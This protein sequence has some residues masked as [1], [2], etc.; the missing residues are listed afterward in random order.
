MHYQ[1][2]TTYERLGLGPL[3]TTYVGISFCRQL[4]S[5]GLRSRM[6]HFDPLKNII[7][8]ILLDQWTS[9]I[10]K[11]RL[12]YKIHIQ[13]ISPMKETFRSCVDQRM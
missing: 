9:Y 5:N 10:P 8:P 6:T 11:S 3:P 12:G 1:I 13:Y 2:Q 7:S 4:T